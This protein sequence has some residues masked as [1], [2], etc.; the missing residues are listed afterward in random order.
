MSTRPR[1]A[2]LNGHHAL[3]RRDRERSIEHLT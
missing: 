2:G 1:A 3:A